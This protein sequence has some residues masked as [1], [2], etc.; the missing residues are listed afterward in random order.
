MKAYTHSKSFDLFKTT[1]ERIKGN[2]TTL[3]YLSTLD[4]FLWQALVPIHT[5]CPALF[6]NYLAKVVAHQSLRPSTKFTSLTAE[7]RVK[8]PVHLFNMLTA[9]DIPQAHNFAKTMYLNRGLLFGFLAL[10]HN[11]V[12]PYMKLHSAFYEMDTLVRAHKIRQL[13]ISVGLRNGGVLYAAIQQSAFWY[14]KARWF[15][16]MIIEKYTRMTIN[17][18]RMAYKDFNHFVP[19]DDCVQIFMQ[20]LSRAID[21]CNP[22]QGVLTTFIQNWF[23]SGRSEVARMAKGQADQSYE[24]MSED[25][26]DAAQ[27][28]LGITDPDRSVELQQT[29]AEAA[30]DVDLAGSVRASLDI[31]EILTYADR[32]SLLMFVEDPP[33]PVEFPEPSHAHA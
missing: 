28:A 27:L 25:H 10:F 15:K 12:R 5:E 21:R 2:Y 18:A 23:K 29:I 26:G 17:N 8:L 6:N 30:R 3:Q 13:E 9:P 4:D 20:V 32:Q 11:M 31:R 22:R 19:L 1:E 14:E 16:H 7:E 24:S 33:E